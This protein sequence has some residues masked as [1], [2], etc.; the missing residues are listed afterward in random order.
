MRWR[1]A[2]ADETVQIVQCCHLVLQHILLVSVEPEP[3]PASEERAVLKHGDG[4]RVE[5]PEGALAS[6]G[7]G[8]T[9]PGHLDEAVI[10]A[11]VVPQ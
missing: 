8:V 3:L 10:E 11:Q 5:S 1:R 2:R 7:G 4:L 6:P 9:L